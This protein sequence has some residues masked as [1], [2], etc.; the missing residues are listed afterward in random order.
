MRGYAPCS[1]A[2]AEAEWAAATAAGARA[3]LLGAPDYPAQ[4]ALIPDPPPQRWAR[5]D[6]GLADR[7]AG[8]YSMA[9]VLGL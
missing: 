5:G 2:E 1:R 9:E 6:P 4:F 7:P 8:R 3:L